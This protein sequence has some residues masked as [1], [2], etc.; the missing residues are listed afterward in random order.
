MM[1]RLS[2]H[3]GLGNDFLVLLTADPDQI[4]DVDAW[5]ARARAWCHRH[6]GIGADGLLLGLHGAAAGDVDLVMRLH[7]ADGSLAEMSGN[8]IRCLAHA[9]AIRRG[10]AEG[11]L[12][13]ATD[14]GLRTVAIGPDPS[15]HAGIV[16]ARVEM[17][18]AR[19]GPEADH[20]L[21]VD[22]IASP[23]AHR[24]ALDATR[25]VTLD[26]GNPHLVLLVD[27]PGAVDMAA[28]GPLHEACFGAGINVHAVAA[29]PGEP[30]AITMQVW[31][32]GVGLTEA[33]G[34]GAT[35]V[36][37]AMHDWGITGDR[38]TVHMPGGDVVVEVGD[39]MVLIGPSEHVADLEVPA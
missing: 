6:R 26:L 9:E 15:G 22:G 33:C 8:G 3:H 17:G 31:E 27:E 10:E 36:A 19:P 5:A 2:K 23:L 1:F 11:A 32:R 18:P 21:A 13:I 14:G 34:T 20:P 35:A 29:T 38:V 7:N 4:A 28:A 30:D 37:R 12:S 16:Q 39:P 25:S 24:Y